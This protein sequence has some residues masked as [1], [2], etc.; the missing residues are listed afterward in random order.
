MTKSD[1]ESKYNK[2]GGKEWKEQKHTAVAHGKAGDK[3]YE[4]VLIKNLRNKIC[5]L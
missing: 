3:I 4:Y 5:W 2:S 1:F